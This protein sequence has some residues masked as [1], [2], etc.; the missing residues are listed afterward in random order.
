MAQI[1]NKTAAELVDITEKTWFI[2]NPLPQKIVLDCG[3]KY[4]P[5]FSKMC[6]NDHGLNRKTITNRNHNS[7]AI[8][9]RIHQII[10]N[11][12]RKFDVSNIVKNNPWSG[13]LAVTMIVFGWDSILNIKHVAKW[14]HIR[15]RKQLH[16]N[17][18]NKCENMCRNNHQYKVGDKVIVKH[19]KKSKH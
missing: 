10:G 9:E 12:I 1:P 4:M 17:H 3:T 16:I 8:I 2:R 7:N 5:K 11:I 15:Q 13:I 19:K 14:E 6:Q 18:N